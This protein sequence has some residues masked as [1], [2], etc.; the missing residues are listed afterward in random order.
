MNFEKLQGAIGT[1]LR[2]N[3]LPNRFTDE[4]FPLDKLDDIWILEMVNRKAGLVLR[5]IHTD[6]IL[7]L[8]LDHVHH[9]VT[10]PQSEIDGS[11]H[12]FL[13]LNVEINICRERIEIFPFSRPPHAF[14]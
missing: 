1:R 13:L 10:D 7:E 8:G 3:P 4:G 2:L 14:T 6:H 5:N 12:G 11:K 9:F